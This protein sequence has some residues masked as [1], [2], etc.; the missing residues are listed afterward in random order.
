MKPAQ[1]G[2]KAFACCLMTG[3]QIAEHRPVIRV[4]QSVEM[5]AGKLFDTAACQGAEMIVGRDDLSIEILMDDADHL[6]VGNRLDAAQ[7]LF[8]LTAHGPLMP[9]R[10]QQRQRLIRKTAQQPQLLGRGH[11][12]AG[13]RVETGNE[14]DHRAFG[15]FYWRCRN[16]T[17]HRASHHQ[18]MCAELGIGPHIG[19]GKRPFPPKTRHEERGGQRHVSKREAGIGQKAQV[20]SIRHRDNRMGHRQNVGRHARKACMGIVFRRP[21]PGHQGTQIFR[22][23]NRR[24]HQGIAITFFR[25]RPQIRAR[26]QNKPD[27]RGA[28]KQN[29]CCLAPTRKQPLSGAMTHS[30]A[31]AF[32]HEPWKL[33]SGFQ[34]EA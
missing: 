5:T 30:S 25:A 12:N 3:E 13:L 11:F 19:Q 7:L 28:R 21:R 33:L 8:Q 9:P 17:K 27:Y 34:R 18:R 20:L 22:R 16:E 29:A 14:P 15:R 6:L 32:L 26:Q 2:C 1:L 4:D 23:H 10:R 31:I 24:S